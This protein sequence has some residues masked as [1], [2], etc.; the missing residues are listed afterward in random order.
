M[1]FLWPGFLWS[2]L[3]VP[4]LPV[5]Y[6][7]LLRRRRQQVLRYSSLGAVRAAAGRTW[8]RHVPA[9]LLWLA[10]AVLTLAL[11]RPTA[12]ITLPWSSA[13]IILAMD[14]S[15]SMRVS[16]VKPTRLVAAQDAAKAVSCTI[17]EE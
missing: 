12:P 13:S 9:G 7:W 1:S 16:D 15:L 5:L 17:D 8:R 4:L 14:V 11:A 3:A 10:L 2:L 6:V